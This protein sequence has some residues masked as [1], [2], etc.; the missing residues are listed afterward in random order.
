MNA[1]GATNVRAA[2]QDRDA[3]VENGWDLL[4]QLIVLGSVK[5]F[6]LEHLAMIHVNP[7]LGLDFQLGLIRY[8]YEDLK[9]S[10]SSNLFTVPFPAMIK[11]FYVS[12][13]LEDLIRGI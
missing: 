3:T 11:E 2:K 4:R 8:L 1:V 7:N 12:L 6:I 10:Q 13:S 5:F 9:N